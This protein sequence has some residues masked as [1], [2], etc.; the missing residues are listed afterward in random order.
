MPLQKSKGGV[1]MKWLIAADSSCDLSSLETNSEQIGFETVPFTVTVDGKDFEDDTTLNTGIMVDVMEKGSSSHTSC[2]SPGAWYECFMKADQVIAFTIS[3]NLSGSLNSAQ[4]AREMVLESHPEKKIEIV[5]SLSTGPKLVM[6]AQQA[7][8]M[9]HQ[10]AS[11]AR[12]AQA[13]RDTA[14]NVHTIFTLCSFHNLVQNGRI[15]KIAGFIAGKLNL[16][17]IGAGSH[18]GHIQM[19]DK[20]LGD[21]K[22]L[23]AIVDQMVTN[24]YQGGPIAISHCLNEKLA[25][26]LK[27]MVHDRWCK[28]H[29]QILPTRGLDSYY[30]ERNGLIISY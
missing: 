23:R 15:S 21:T 8:S 22:A 12:I 5:D 4:I 9:I 20:V 11:L 3:S 16:R 17:V 25:E 29:V 10:Q 2:P 13:C 30:A 24:G 26:Q 27:N 7:L 19:K 18:D 6:M 28:A 14:Q 1:C